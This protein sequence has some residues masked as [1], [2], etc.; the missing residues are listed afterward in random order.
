MKG[1]KNFLSRKLLTSKLLRKLSY[2]LRVEWV[3][4]ICVL[5]EMEICGIKLNVWDTMLSLLVN[6]KPYTK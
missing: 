4:V 6:K 2:V 5:R 1:K 3:G